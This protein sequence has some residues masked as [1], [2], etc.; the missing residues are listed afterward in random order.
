[1]T[2]ICDRKDLLLKRKGGELV[3]MKWTVG[4]NK[5]ET[6]HKF[7]KNE[8][9]ANLLPYEKDGKWKYNRSLV[10]IDKERHVRR[11]VVP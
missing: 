9:K 5:K 11:A 2:Q 7:I 6:L 3:Q 10:L 1:M 8:F 4:M